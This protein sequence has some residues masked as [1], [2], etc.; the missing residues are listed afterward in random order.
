M[1]IVGILLGIVLLAM[2]FSVDAIT[3][4]EIKRKLSQ[5]Q[6]QEDVESVIL[7][8]VKSSEYQ[9]ACKLLFDKINSMPLETQADVEKALPTLQDYENLKCQ[10]TKGIWGDPPEQLSKTQC[11]E[12]IVRFEE[13]NDKYYDLQKEAEIIAVDKGD[14]KASRWLSN[15]EVYYVRVLASEAKEEYRHKCIPDPEQCDGLYAESSMLSERWFDAEE[16]SLEQKFYSQD[17]KRIQDR[18]SLTCGY[19]SSLM[20]YYEAQE[21]YL[22][23]PMPT[24]VSSSEIVCGEGTIENTFGQCVPIQTTSQEQSRGGGCLIATA[25]YG[26]ELASQ[27]Q[28]LR[29][30]RDNSLLQTES[31]SAFM[32]SFNQ[33]Y[34]SFSPTIA[35]FERQNPV[36][37]EAVKLTITPLLTSLSLLNY[38]DTD[39]EVDV[40]GYG[41]SLILLNV[42]MYFVAPTIIIVKIGNRFRKLNI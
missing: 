36:F 25:T 21:K 32:E 16:H 31:G 19:Q 1:K 15:S 3:I 13:Y 12:L 34:Y 14:D 27:V 35:D 24:F 20:Q 37:K 42:G 18:S 7:E 17:L 33:F 41:I 10:Y 23:I 22:N 29:E 9:E 28:Q 40:L 4:S 5:T 39:S 11:D 30:I 2:P 8:I 6:S 38:V 26:S